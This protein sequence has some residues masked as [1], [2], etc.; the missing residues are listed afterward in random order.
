MTHSKLKQVL[1]YMEHDED[2]RLSDYAKK[3]KLAKTQIAREGIQMR[4]NGDT[5]PYNAGFNQGLRES[6]RIVNDTQGAKMM[7]PSGKSFGQ[8]VVEGIEKFLREKI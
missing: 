7:F 5:D 3:N 2:K 4:L 8:L 6:I 1:I